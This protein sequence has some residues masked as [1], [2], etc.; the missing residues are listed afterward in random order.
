MLISKVIFKYSWIYDQKFKKS[1]KTRN[2][3]STKKIMNYIKKVEKIWSKIDKEIL[4]ELS[5]VSRL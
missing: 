2:Y 5:R 1:V 3:P 4:R